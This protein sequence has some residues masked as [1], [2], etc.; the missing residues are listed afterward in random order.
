MHFTLSGDGMESFQG[1]IY[2]QDANFVMSSPQVEVYVSGPTKWIY[3]VGINEVMVM[4]HDPTMV[5]IFQNPLSLFSSNLSKEY[6]VS[7]KPVY[8][9]K[10]GREVTEISLTPTGKGVPY[11]LVVLRLDRQSQTPQ[12]I[13]FDAKDGSR[14]E[15]VITGYKPLSKPFSPEYFTF[16]TQKHPEVYVT[17]LR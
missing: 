10:E 17:D 14:F 4:P 9:Q 7:D 3:S 8:V 15:V 1:T 16:P 13:Q 11:T 12:S 5:D 6:K 2:A